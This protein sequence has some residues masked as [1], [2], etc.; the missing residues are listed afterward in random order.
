MR[1][2]Y[3]G[4]YDKHI[5]RIVMS[6]H[7][8]TKKR[9]KGEHLG[10]RERDKLEM[11][12]REDERKPK[13]KR[14]SQRQLA[15]LL[16][17][18]P[19]TISRELK[20]GRIGP[21]Y[22][23]EL[24]QYYSYSADVAQDHY[25]MQS[26]A[27]GKH[28]KIRKDHAFAKYISEQIL[29]QKQSPDAIIMRLRREGNPFQTDI[30]TRTLYS[31]LS[32]GIIPG[33]ALSDLPYAGLQPKRAYKRVRRALKGD[34]KSVEDRPTQANT[35][36]EEG[37]WEMDCIV[38]GKGKQQGK[39]CLLVM[40]ER[41][42]REVIIRKL[43]T[44][45]GQSVLA[46]LNSIERSLGIKA[47]KERF[48]TITTDN[49]HEFLDWR[50]METSCISGKK[51]TVQYYCHPYSSWER[52]SVENSNRLIRRFIPKGTD[53]SKVSSKFI[54]WIQEWINDLPRR[55]LNGMSARIASGRPEAA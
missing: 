46:A 34:G 47:F 49:G 5:R 17:C 30:C 43:W 9:K 52:G 4:N 37:H 55:I 33:V 35:R 12:I 26:T 3:D 23:K 10:Y 27:K 6:H 50:A 51:R 25:E 16:K 45:T 48:K 40:T 7:K 21:L 19:A 36:E 44:H 2:L 32:M 54:R 31:Y 22:G 15:W 20:R 14:R 28:L 29:V 53:L 1:I 39:T 18:S 38:S 8:Y 42:T 41:K 13:S 11:L 24:K